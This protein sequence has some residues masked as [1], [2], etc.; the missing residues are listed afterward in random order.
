MAEL[1]GLMEQ[2][3]VEFG[4]GFTFHWRK[5]PQ[6]TFMESR[7]NKKQWDIIPTVSRSGDVTI[8]YITIAHDFVWSEDALRALGS[9][10]ATIPIWEFDVRVDFDNDA[11][12]KVWS[13][14]GHARG[15]HR[16]NIRDI[17]PGFHA[18][19]GLFSGPISQAK[20]PEL[21]FWDCKFNEAASSIGPLLNARRVRFETCEFTS[22]DSMGG[23]LRS[24]ATNQILQD[25]KLYKTK[26][27]SRTD[28]FYFLCHSPKLY[29][30]NMERY[31]ADTI[32]I[33]M[34]TWELVDA[35]VKENPNLIHVNV[36][37]RLY[38]GP[39][40]TRDRGYDEQP[41]DGPHF[42]PG[43]WHTQKVMPAQKLMA[44]IER[45]C[46]AN[47]IK[48]AKKQMQ[49]DEIPDGIRLR[50][51]AKVMGGVQKWKRDD[52]FAMLKDHAD[53]FQHLKA[54]D[55]SSG[56]GSGDDSTKPPASKRARYNTD[57]Y[58]IAPFPW[59]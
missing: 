10:V 20:V 23:M 13:A 44:S 46:R 54:P 22:S 26:L 31:E 6:K 12:C 36:N 53:F 40:H 18:F 19:T 27:L 7:D 14:L 55:T 25:F 42:T 9:F 30:V 32:P 38:G 39:P 16:I 15:M 59:F 48:T 28:L 29:K 52:K 8:V 56:D 45:G 21:D 2:R 1:Q 57:G 37:A 47:L 58:H 41:Y 17:E 49:D 34:L 43:D 5:S 3:F 35:A 4:V 11:A 33:D 50:M 51:W 24:L